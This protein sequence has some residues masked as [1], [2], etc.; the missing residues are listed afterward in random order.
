M[1]Q[2][3]PHEA[4]YDGSYETH[5]LLYKLSSE[6]HYDDPYHPRVLYTE[7]STERW[8]EALKHGLRDD[9]IKRLILVDKSPVSPNFMFIAACKYGNIPFAQWVLSTYPDQ[10]VPHAHDNQAFVLACRQGHFHMV[11]WLYSKFPHVIHIYDPIKNGFIC[12]CIR[13]HFFIAKWLLGVSS[14]VRNQFDK[15]DAFNWSCGQGHLHIAQWLVRRFPEINPKNNYRYEAFYFA[16]KNNHLRVAQWL[17][18]VFPLTKQDMWCINNTFIT[19]SRKGHL[20]VIQW[21]FNEI[22]DNLD[23]DLYFGKDMMFRIACM[24]GHLHVVQWLVKMFPPNISN[25]SGTSLSMSTTFFSTCINGHLPVAQWLVKVFPNIDPYYDN[26][27][28]LREVRKNGHPKV[29]QWLAKRFPYIDFS[30]EK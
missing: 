10:V 26:N 22:Q 20:R 29:A 19:T 8:I 18:R 27:R 3:T 2:P 28:S 30:V 1:D 17:A 21:L 23:D 14:P 24:D 12:A 15:D 25:D 4:I 5:V 11:E 13:G 9:F 16:C 7:P 6:F